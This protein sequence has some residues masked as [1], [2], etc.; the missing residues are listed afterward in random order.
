MALRQQVGLRQAVDGTGTGENEP[1]DAVAQC[2]LDQH[3]RL[4]RV[5]MQ[6]AFGLVHRFADL[7]VAGEMDHGARTMAA[8]HV[9]ETRRV[10]DIAAL[11]RPPAHGP[12]M[13]FLQCVE[14]DG[15]MAR[16]GQRLADV[17]ADIARA[18]GDQD[19]LSHARRRG[20]VPGEGFEPPTFGLQSRCPPGKS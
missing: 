10:A 11:E 12:L 18:A 13:A 1:I 20:L 14:A 6:I 3:I 8:E 5:V 19:G 4:V 16:L 17:A 15:L 9:G 2:A 7:D